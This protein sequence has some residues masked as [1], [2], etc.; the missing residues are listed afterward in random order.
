M[1]ARVSSLWLPRTGCGPAEYQ[2]AFCPRV[3]GERSGPRLRFALADG[4]TESLLS[5]RWADLLVR[6]YCRG[7]ARQVAGVLD[8]AREIWNRQLLTY[9][10]QRED[11]GRPIQWFEE[12]G[13]AR[14]AHATFLGVQ[15]SSGRAG[16]RRGA[17]SAVAIGDTCLFHL[18]EG[19]LLASFPID[20]AGLFSSSPPLVSSRRNGAP[21]RTEAA[22]GDW[23]KGDTF[24]MA[25]DALARWFLQGAVAGRS[26]WSELASA[27]AAGPAPFA[28]WVHE[29]RSLREMA[30]DDVT[31][32]TVDVL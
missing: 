9:P 18:R 3:D 26:P 21:D 25:T 12:R 19:R 8:G 10:Q 5:G 27:V 32:V 28:E 13:L 17:W 14:G 7:P 1:R 16:S 11:A 24:V 23:L 15:L 6:N 4:A 20:E 22:R 29:R 30:D 31:A 2:D